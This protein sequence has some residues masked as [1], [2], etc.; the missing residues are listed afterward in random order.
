M[1]TELEEARRTRKAFEERKE[2]ESW[3]DTFFSSSQKTLRDLNACVD[4]SM[5][6]SKKLMAG[7]LDVADSMMKELVQE[8]KA[9]SS[10]FLSSTAASFTAPAA[11]LQ[12]ATAGHEGDSA[13]SDGLALSLWPKAFA[14]Q[15]DLTKVS[16][17]TL[18]Q[19]MEELLEENH[20]LQ[21]ERQ[22]LVNQRTRKSGIGGQCSPRRTSPRGSGYVSRFASAPSIF[23]PSQSI[24]QLPTVHERTVQ[25]P[26]Q[27]VSP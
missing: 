4:Q 15:M 26:T 25:Q 11:S 14:A 1:Q 16:A 23:S 3:L 18:V 22:E 13:A 19:S 24:R 27:L 12:C 17:A 2:R 9:S 5:A 10:S 6:D 8:L 21:Q 20:R 7:R